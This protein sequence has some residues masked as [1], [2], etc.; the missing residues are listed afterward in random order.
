MNEVPASKDSFPQTTITRDRTEWIDIFKGVAIVMVL[1][2]HSGSPVTLYIYLFHMSAF[3]FISG[4]TCNV[5]K[6]SAFAYVKRKVQTILIPYILINLLY[7]LLFY[8]FRLLGLLSYIQENG[9]FSLVQSAANF[10]KYQ[11]TPDLG[12]AT[13]FLAVLF[14][15]EIIYMVIYKVFSK[16]KFEKYAPFFG[17]IVGLLGYYLC[18][19]APNL[20]FL[21]DL[22]LYGILFYS[23]GVIF[24]KYNVFTEKIDPKPM[25]ILSVFVIICFRNFGYINWPT[26]TFDLPINLITSI[27][28]IY[29][30]YRFSRFLANYAA[31]KK[32]FAFLGKITFC[33]L[34]LHFA[35]FKIISLVLVLLKLYPAEIIKSLVPPNGPYVTWLIYT[36]F[37][38]LIC[39]A[40]S[41]IAKR[42]R[43]LNYVVN[44][45]WNRT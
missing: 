45:K 24:K 20:Y 29:L 36:V 42:N 2:G 16:L 31:A 41:V 32:P 17:L 37:A 6:Y 35:V 39:S 12:G 10:V 40:I 5:S 44:A 9:Q 27:C 8:G 14:S 22:S 38:L 15:F 34:T 11:S 43:V 3:M 4:F 25:F 28:G 1:L 23:L 26:R 21:F 30:L 33:I 18:I 7:M 19:N 13:W